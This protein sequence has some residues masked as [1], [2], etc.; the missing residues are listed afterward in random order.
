MILL[1]IFKDSRATG[2]AGV[3]LLLVAIFIPSFIDAFQTGGTTD[4]M[5]HTAMPLYNLVFGAIHK[6]PVLNYFIAMLIMMLISY[7]LIRIGVRD[8]LLQERSLMPA[9]FFILVSAALPQ[10]REVSPALIGSLFYLLCL[11]ILFEAQ[12]SPP[13]TLILFSASLILVLGS[14]FCLKLIW[15]IPLIWVSLWTLRQVTW[16]ELLYPVTAYALLM[17][18][19]FTWFWGVKGNG[20]G[21]AALLSDNLK[22]TGALE[23]YHFSVYLYYGYMLLLVV[24]ASAYMVTRFQ[25]M[26]TMAQKI[27]QVMFYMFL[28]GIL[29]FIFIARFDPSCLVYIAIPVTFVLSNFF[30]RRKSHW[31]HE[32]VLWI[33]AGLAVYV[34]WML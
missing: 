25:T 12:E 4:L 11:A 6:V 5:P 20:A 13:D 2:T 17:L 15:F 24:I 26:K 14:M 27:Y 9:I 1:R 19:L 22:F 10:A 31:I 23:S 7:T 16:R 28:A 29:F 30:H 21:F 34:Q 3:I 32:G 18:F 33:L 8:Q